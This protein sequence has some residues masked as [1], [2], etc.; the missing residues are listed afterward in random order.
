MWVSSN[1][2]KRKETETET[3]MGNGNERKEKSQ[4]KQKPDLER[5]PPKETNEEIRKKMQNNSP[6]PAMQ[7]RH[8]TPG[9]GEK[10]GNF[11]HRSHWNGIQANPMELSKGLE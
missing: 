9:E 5:C 2:D 6:A 4:G 8:Q 11:C 7:N 10:R 3:K 1:N